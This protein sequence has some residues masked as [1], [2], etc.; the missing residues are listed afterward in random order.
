MIVVIAD[1][2]T[3]A[4]EIGGLGLQYGLDTEIITSADTTP[5]MADLLI[6]STD[7][8]SMPE[9]RAIEKI[10]SLAGILDDLKPE[11]IFKKIDSV[12]RGHVVAEVTAH[13]T[14][15]GLRKALL[16]P[17]NPA[18]G[19][20]VTNGQY[21][22]NEH[23]IHHTSFAADPEFP[24]LSSEIHAMIRVDKEDICVAIPSGATPPNGII[25]GECTVADDLQTWANQSS[26]NTLLAGSAAFFARI[27]E[28]A[29]FQK[30]KKKVIENHGSQPSLFVCGSTHAY[31]RQLVKKVK[32]TNGP[33][34]FMPLEIIGEANPGDNLFDIWALEIL[35]L[36]RIHQKAIIAVDENPAQG[37]TINAVDLRNKK[38]IVIEK[39][40]RQTAIKE[41]LIEGGSTAAAIINRLNLN[42]FFPVAEP[43]PGVIRMKVNTIDDL[44]LTVKPGSYQWPANTWKF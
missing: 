36:L 25:V 1:D 41:L 34:S 24:I 7:T 9:E 35:S 30:K 27:L 43:A 26:D 4:A 38:A 16:V 3:G 29:G 5:T 20:T 17:A 14:Q 23:P 32:E 18:L 40:F 8:R 28:A 13:L 15:L 19:R 37:V 6:I 31:S 22:I 42:R 10:R 33:V 44:F 11:L 2:F 39:I 12:L 21:F